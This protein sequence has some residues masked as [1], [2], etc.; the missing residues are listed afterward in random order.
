MGQIVTVAAKPS[1]ICYV[2]VGSVAIDVV[3]N[4]NTEICYSA[5]FANRWATISFHN[6]SIGIHSTLPITVLF[7]DE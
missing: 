2:V 7:T 6:G 4:E 5:V 1:E 3:D